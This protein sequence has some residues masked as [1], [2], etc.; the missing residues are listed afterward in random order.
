LINNLPLCQHKNGSA[1]SHGDTNNGK[2]SVFYSSGLEVRCCCRL[3]G[4]SYGFGNR[5]HGAGRGGPLL[6]AAAAASAATRWKSQKL[7]LLMMRS[8]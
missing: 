3:H 2:K 4:R 1:E 7:V 8:S 6:P 5:I